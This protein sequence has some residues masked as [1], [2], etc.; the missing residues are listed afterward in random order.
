MAYP[1][2]VKGVIIEN[3]AFVLLARVVLSSGANITQ[4]VVSTVRV[5]V[6]NKATEAQVGADFNPAVNTVVYDALQKDARWTKDATGYN[7][8]IELNGDT[9]APDGNVT[10]RAQV[11]M[12]PAGG[13]PFHILY[14][15]QAI[16]ILGE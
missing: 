2:I 7:L 14:D 10:Y 5:R 15:L 4:A 3:S 9:Y 13:N 1:E 8:A 16:N 11:K 6:F 12:T